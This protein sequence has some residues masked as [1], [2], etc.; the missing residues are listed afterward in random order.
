M[1]RMVPS[2]NL[3]YFFSVGYLN[4]YEGVEK[5]EPKTLVD[6]KLPVFA[7]GADVI[8]TDKIQLQ[9]PKLNYVDGDIELLCKTLTYDELDK[10]KAKPRPERFMTPRPKKPWSK[11]SSFFAPKVQRGATKYKSNDELIAEC[12]EFDW[13]CSKLEKWLETVPKPQRDDVFDY[14]KSNYHIM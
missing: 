12:F 4:A 6:E 13:R 10:M 14:L 3:T 2:G 1:Y 11:F 8:Q 7:N 5:N 9:V